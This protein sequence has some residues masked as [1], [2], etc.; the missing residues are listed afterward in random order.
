[1]WI[2]FVCAIA[3][4]I[5][6]VPAADACKCAQ[7]TVEGRFHESDSI[8]TA[9]VIATAPG[10]ITLYGFEGPGYRV[11]LRVVRSFKGPY[12][13][14]DKDVYGTFKAGQSCGIPV[15]VGLQFLVYGDRGWFL[16][17]CNSS[18]GEQMNAGIAKLD[19]FLARR[20]RR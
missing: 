19:A 3:S 10:V 17:M 11:Y 7:R 12:R 5:A 8:F 2:R 9:E 15:V 1:M 18:T 13:P 14:G 4:L 20:A 6:I 16:G